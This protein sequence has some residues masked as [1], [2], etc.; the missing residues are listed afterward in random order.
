MVRRLGSQFQDVSAAETYAT[1]PARRTNSTRSTHGW[2]PLA[3]RWILRTET[4]IISSTH[5]TLQYYT[6]PSYNST[7]TRVPE[8]RLA[9]IPSKYIPHLRSKARIAIPLWFR[10]GFNHSRVMWIEVEVQLR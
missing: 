7:I 8:K 9:R 5:N 4:V 1:G 10:S 2:V 3:C 6:R